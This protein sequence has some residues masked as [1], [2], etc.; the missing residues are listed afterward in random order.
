MSRVS[1]SSWKSSKLS[2]SRRL[3]RVVSP[4]EIS[5]APRLTRVVAEP[6]P[7]DL[8]PFVP[9]LD[10]SK[11]RMTLASSPVGSL[12]LHPGLLD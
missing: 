4:W 11:T 7:T 5:A 8:S 10:L 9:V 6:I 1:P 2:S 3:A 12:D